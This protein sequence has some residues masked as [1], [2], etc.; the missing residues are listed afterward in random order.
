MSSKKLYAIIGVLVLCLAFLSY[1]YID[2]NNDYKKYKSRYKELSILYLNEIMEPPKLEA[3]SPQD[4][5]ITNIDFDTNVLQFSN[6]D[7]NIFSI[8]D[9]KGKN[10]FINYWA[11]WCNPCLAEMP[12]MA[13]LYDRFK[14][15]EDIA[16]LYL[17]RE[18][19]NTIKEY[20]PNDESLQKIPIYKVLTD[21]EFFA[22]SGIP[23]T[24]IINSN[25]EVVVK[26]IGS[27][28][29]NDESVFKFIDDLV[30]N[31]EV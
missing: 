7:G 15:N 9:F 28:F 25:G 6:L 24:F 5:E 20:I 11:T 16:F 10:L 8:Q 31:N 17:S 12:S 1:Q 30:R 22:T 3:P 13:E 4:M 26:D 2:T 27:A 23:T 19:L 14:D 18:E 29:W 21:D